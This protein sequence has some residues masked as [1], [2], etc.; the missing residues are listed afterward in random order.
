MRP[1]Q[2]SDYLGRLRRLDGTFAIRPPDEW[3]RK[4]PGCCRRKGQAGLVLRNR[5]LDIREMARCLIRL[6]SFVFVGCLLLSACSNAVLISNEQVSQNYRP[7]DLSL[8][9]TR[10]NELRVLIGGN[11]FQTSDE[12]L[13]AQVV[14]SMTGR[15]PGIA[16]NFSVS[17]TREYSGGRLRY[18]VR[19]VFDPLPGVNTI[20]LCKLESL[21]DAGDPTPD[22]TSRL[23]VLAAYCQGEL[24]L[25]R[26]TAST[27]RMQEAG[28]PAFDQLMVQLTM[29]L[30]PITNKSLAN[31]SAVGGPQLRPLLDV[32][33]RPE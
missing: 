18:N 1:V 9:A 8:I 6:K 11:P 10:E 14:E 16:V 31:A 21:E 29:T 7:G 28:A 26:A 32:A 17:P 20:E 23:R 13:A 12:A 22:A 3:N 27:A 25:T 24:A 30:F 33:A 5:V 19:M 4:K 2:E 15:T